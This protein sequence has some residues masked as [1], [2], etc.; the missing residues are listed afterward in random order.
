MDSVTDKDVHDADSATNDRNAETP[1]V[2]LES[3]FPSG[4]IARREY[5]IAC[6]SVP[7]GSEPAH[8]PVLDVR[9]AGRLLLDTD[10]L[11][12]VWTGPGSSPWE[13]GR[14]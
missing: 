14:Q 11:R 8:W 7:P 6:E 12:A 10:D 4:E 2:V 1:I 5:P 9:E 13:G 3:T